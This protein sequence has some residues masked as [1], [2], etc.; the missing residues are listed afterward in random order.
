MRGMMERT[1]QMGIT[2]AFLDRAFSTFDFNGVEL[3]L[4]TST[5]DRE[6]SLMVGNKEI[7]LLEVGPAHTLGDTLIYVPGDRVVYAGDIL[8]IGVHPV[9]WTGPTENWLRALD[10]ILEMDV[11]TIV[12][13]HGPLTDK[14]HVRALRDYFEYLQREAR[15]RYMD[16]MTAFQAAEEIANEN[17]PVWENPERIVVNVMAMY[18]EFSGDESIPTRLDSFA[19][20][21][22][23]DYQR[24]R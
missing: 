22:T 19:A 11:K 21:A 13:G 3:T 14:D 7:R 8:F 20:M 23:F 6:A 10:L 4:P 16:G 5:F 12:P 15:S 17:G 1:R 9:I 2:G 18:R 24:R